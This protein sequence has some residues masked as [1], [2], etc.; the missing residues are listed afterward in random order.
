MNQAILKYVELNKTDT[1]KF[2]KILDPEFLLDEYHRIVYGNLCLTYS[3]DQNKENNY[4]YIPRDGRGNNPQLRF[5]SERRKIIW[6][7]ISQYL[8]DLKNQK[9]ESFIIR[10]HRL[11]RSI[12]RKD[13][14][15][16]FTHI[17]VDEFQDCTRADYEIFY[18]M[19]QNPNNLTLAGD[20][21][22]S[23]NLGASLHI[24]KANDQRNFLRKKLDGSFRL[25]FR[26]SECIKPLSE[27]ISKK[28]GEREGIQS[29]IIN[30]YKG[31]PPGS[32]PI[33]VAKFYL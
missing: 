18:N 23:I 12:Q 25:P 2:S 8:R 4:A 10:R 21:A 14:P 11:L 9:L 24:P 6:S 26:V 13:F 1:K 15:T 22:Q 7:I 19:L 17:I 5:N 29:D 27:L 33:F 16:K 31:A 30:P 28:F 20:I 32:R 3:K